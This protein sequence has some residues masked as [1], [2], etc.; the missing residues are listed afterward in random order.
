MRVFALADPHL[1]A[2]DPKPMDVFGPHWAGHPERLFEAWNEVVDAGDLV[3]VPGDISWAMRLPDALPDLQALAAL[4]G[5]KVLLRGNHGL[6][7]AVY[8]QVAQKPPRRHVRASERRAEVRFCHRRR[9]ARLGLPRQ[10]RL[11]T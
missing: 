4:P 10:R 5:Q 3:L 1:S 9:D 11:F 8:H 2:V 6:L 7:V